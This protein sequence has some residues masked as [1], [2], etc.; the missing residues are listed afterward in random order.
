VIYLDN[1]ATSFPKAP[2]VAE[3]VSR[4]LSELPGSAGRASHAYAREA[5][6]V[7]YEARARLASFIGAIPQGEAPQAE[8]LIFT[9]S[10]TEA[11]NLA[12]LGLVPS[13]GLVA[14]SE[15]E[16]NAVMRPLRYLEAE[17]GVRLI[18]FPCDPSGR[19]DPR[20]LAE[21]LGMRPDLL[22]MSAASNVTGALPP[23]AEVSEECARKRTPLLV[24]GSQLVGHLPFSVSSLGLS[25]F[26]FSGHKG[27]LGPAGTG[28]LWMAPGVEPVPLIRGGTGSA[29]ESETQPDFLPD[30]YEAGTQNIAALAG[31]SAALEYLETETL[32]RVASR[33]AALVERLHSG[34]L[35]LPGVSV[36]GPPLGA[37]RAP[38]LSFVAEGLDS[39]EVAR[40][41]DLR[42]IACRMGLHC[43]PSAHKS[44]GTFERGGSIRLSP[45]YFTAEG[46]IDETIAA[47]KEILE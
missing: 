42:G 5:S 17:R 1:A 38:L 44:A 25:L 14:A 40:E 24:D 34:L 31:L 22:V 21:A 35:S 18:I 26:A 15:L 29:S 43:A 32:S 23:L 39:G 13:G 28:A 10:A 3:A 30:R 36:S 19:P 2:G 9:K 45:S 20:A 16:H 7:L 27:L 12:I 8:R 6:E 33:E 46:E 37:P 41:L 4:S 47:L 11:L